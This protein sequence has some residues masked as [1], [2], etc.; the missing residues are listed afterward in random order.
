VVARRAGAAHPQRQPWA[1][2]GLALPLRIR[3]IDA[4]MVRMTSHRG[5]SARLHCSYD[6]R[7]QR[8]DQVVITDEQHAEGLQHFALHPDALI[9]ADR[10]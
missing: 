4:S 7:E 10:W 6:L 2:P 9:V 8:L 1:G 5:R 3:V